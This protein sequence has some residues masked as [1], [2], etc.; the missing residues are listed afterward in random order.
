MLPNQESIRSLNCFAWSHS[1]LILEISQQAVHLSF[2]REW[3]CALSTTACAYY[4]VSLSFPDALGRP[5]SRYSRPVRVQRRMRDGQR[6]LM[7]V[8]R[9]NCVPQSSGR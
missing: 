5:D 4:S 2:A 7:H 1:L 3:H 8:V 6:E 9:L